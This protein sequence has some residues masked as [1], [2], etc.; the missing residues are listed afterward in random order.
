MAREFDRFFRENCDTT[1]RGLILDGTR[2]DDAHDAAQE[3]Y[4]WAFARWWRVGHYREPAGWVRR[5]AVNITRDQHRRLVTHGK[6]MPKLAATQVLDGPE[7]GT[8][9]GGPLDDALDQLPPQQR[10]AVDLYYGAGFS[11]EEAAGRIG[12]SPGAVCFRLSR[13]RQTLKP[14]TAERIGNQE[15]A[16]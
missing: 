5:V 8:D 15:M 14:R 6:A 3:A 12:I 9:L 7:S 4:V 13:A 11:T 2:A 1:V 16:R 10:Q